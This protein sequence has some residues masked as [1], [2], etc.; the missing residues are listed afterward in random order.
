MF[1]QIGDKVLGLGEH[2]AQVDHPDYKLIRWLSPWSDVVAV[3][4]VVIFNLIRDLSPLTR[5]VCM[6]ALACML[7]ESWGLDRPAR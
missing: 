6:R 1:F 3:V 7:L 4:A 2:L 5:F